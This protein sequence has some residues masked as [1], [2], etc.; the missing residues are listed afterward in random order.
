[1]KRIY[2][3]AAPYLSKRS[4]LQTLQMDSTISPH[5][6][7]RPATLQDMEDIRRMCLDE[8]WI[9][10]A[11]NRMSDI[12]QNGIAR[13]NTADDG[14]ILSKYVKTFCGKISA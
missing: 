1:M 2:A 10:P 14:T 8:G 4:L 13:V 7:V 9:E 3:H 6:A 12:I 11:Q 5:T